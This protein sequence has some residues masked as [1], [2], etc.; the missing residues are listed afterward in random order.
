MKNKEKELYGIK[1]RNVRHDFWQSETLENK[2][3]FACYNEPLAY[4]HF[5]SGVFVFSS[6]WLVCHRTTRVG[7][8]KWVGLGSLEINKLIDS[9]QYKIVPHIEF[10]KELLTIGENKRKGV[11]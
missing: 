2:T 4:Q 3:Y 6:N 11:R 8:S 7:V 10:V 5:H 9:G 1:W